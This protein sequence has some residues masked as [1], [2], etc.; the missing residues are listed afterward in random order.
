MIPDIYAERQPYTNITDPATGLETKAYGIEICN[1]TIG[2]P[3]F[4]ASHMQTKFQHKCS[5]IIKSS[6]ALSSVEVSCSL[7]GTVVF[8]PSPLRLLV[9][10][11]PAKPDPTA[12]WANSVMFE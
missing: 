3:Q 10:N 5:A 2:D 12:R 8:V 11:S 7:P 6:D 1:V 9:L 4:V